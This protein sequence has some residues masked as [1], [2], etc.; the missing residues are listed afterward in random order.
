MEIV[1]IWS[2]TQSLN[3]AFDK[4][5]DMRSRVRAFHLTRFR[6]AVQTTFRC[7]EDLVA[8]VVLPDK[9]AKE[10]LIDTCCIDDCSIPKGAA[11]FN[12]F[13]KNWLCLL[14]SEVGA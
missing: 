6:K 10:F 11:E 3:R 12:G 5:L 9:V 13:E 4:F 7:N 8:D 14:R 1:K 2:E